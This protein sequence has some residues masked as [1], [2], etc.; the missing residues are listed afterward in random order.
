MLTVE[1]NE[2]LCRVGAGTPMGNLMRRYWHPIAAASQLADK[3]VKPI[4]LLGEDLVLFRD[5]SGRLGLVDNRCAHRL[6]KLEYGFPVAEGLR[7]PYHG[8]TYDGKGACVAQPA[9]PAGSTFKDKVHIKSYPVQEMGGVVF[10]YLGPQPAPLLPRWEPLVATNMARVL[11][12]AEIPCNWLQCME[13]SPDLTHTEWLHGHFAQWHLKRVGYSEDHPLFQNT[14]PYMQHQVEN[15]FER[16]PYGI[17][18]RRL[19]EG[20]TKDNENWSVGIP[21]ML[22]NIN[23]TS[24]TGPIL[25]LWRVPMD[26]THTMQWTLSCFRVGDEKAKDTVPHTDVPLK[27]EHGNWN[28]HI[29]TVQDCMA[30][31]AQGEIL[32]RSQERLSVGDVGVILYRQMLF[33]QLDAVEAGRDPINVFRDPRENVSLELPIFNR[34]SFLR[35][36][37]GTYRKGV[38]THTF[39]IPDSAVAK[40]LEALVE[41][42]VQSQR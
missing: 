4:R 14:V 17:I 9:E 20:Q 35:T 12:S 42:S 22:P 26:D 15:A 41:Q 30:F 6:V 39:G 19:I 37:D 33:E 1:Q 16:T 13:N 8:W 27:D 23:L 24:N 38:A 3:P 25:L 34:D 29:L 31:I 2:R 18:R 10:A 28:L 5:T 36:G 11:Y 21:I 32:D 40:E 7:C